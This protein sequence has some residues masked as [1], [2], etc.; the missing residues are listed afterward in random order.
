MPPFTVAS[1]ATIITSRPE[2]R[3]MPVTMPAAG[4]VAVV[5]VVCGQRRQLEKRRAG[6]EQ[7]VDALAHRQLALRAMALDVLGAAAVARAAQPLAQLGDQLLP[8]AH[9]WLENGIGRVDVSLERYHPQ[10]SVL[11]PQAGQR[12]T[13]C[14]RYISPPQRS[15]SVL[16]SPAGGALSADFRGVIGR[17]TGRG[18]SESAMPE[19]MAWRPLEYLQPVTQP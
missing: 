4:R 11:N 19:I 15:Q 3:P 10:Q 13:A 2:T 18:A 17:A 9:G 7:P 5:H 1:L 12:Q 8:C 16:V 14:M 6:I